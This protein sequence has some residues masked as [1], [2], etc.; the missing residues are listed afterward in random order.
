M[1]ICLELSANT[2]ICIRSRPA[3]ATATLSSL[4]LLKSR[5]V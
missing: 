3:D 1:V 2:V 4:A 5:L